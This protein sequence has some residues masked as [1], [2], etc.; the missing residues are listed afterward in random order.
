MKQHRSRGARDAFGGFA[1]LGFAPVVLI[2]AIGFATPVSAQ[3]VDQI[4]GSKSNN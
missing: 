1:K 2:A 3:V 4:S